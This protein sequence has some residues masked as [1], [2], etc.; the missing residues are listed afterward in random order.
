MHVK[1]TL[2]LIMFLCLLCT[3]LTAQEPGHDRIATQK[4]VAKID[5]TSWVADSFIVSP[6][7]RRVAYVSKANDRQSVVVDGKKGQPYDG[8][9]QNSLTFSPDSKRIAYGA[10]IE[11][12]QLV[13]L[14][15]VE[16]NYYDGIV[17]PPL[18]SA[19]SQHSAYAAK[20]GKE[21][22]VIFDRK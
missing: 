9:G 21:A 14:D 2:W 16:G 13:I 3:S 4:P 12:K 19:D 22:F 5:Y 11:G 8:I 17:V 7:A 1:K 18:F 6:D 20:I 15:G 10:G